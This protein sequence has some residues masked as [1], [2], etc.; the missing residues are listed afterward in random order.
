MRLQV[1]LSH[2][3]VCSRRDAMVLVQSGRVKV[4]GLIV[5]EPSFA[6]EAGDDIMAD[7]QKVESKQYSYVML[8]KP[9]GYVTSKEDPHADKTIM[10]LLPKELHHLVPV[11]RLDKESEGLLLLTNDGNLAH[12]LTH[13]KFHVDKTYTVRVG[14]ELAREKKMR[15]E[16][17]V[18]IEGEKTAPCCIRDVQYNGTDTE[19]RMMIH[20]GRKRQI[21][22]MLKAVGSHV[23][24]LK[25]VAV[26]DLKLGDLKTGAW[27]YLDP[28]EVKILR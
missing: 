21:R 11:G 16:H 23:H 7:G 18:V 14:G 5:R 12:R 13:P 6:V 17:G 19:F 26:G 2:N 28:K 8:N 27:R 22:L 24:Y 9:A 3:G 1:F 15:L 25:R 20:E 10:D 4:N